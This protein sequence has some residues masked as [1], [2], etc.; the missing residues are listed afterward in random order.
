MKR[1]LLFFFCGLVL[2]LWSARLQ[3]AGQFSGDF[4]AANKLYEQGHYAEAAAA[5]ETLAKTQS[6]AEALFFNLGNAWFKAGQTGRAIAAWRQAEHL[7]PRDPS[8]RF[9]LR[10]ARKKVAGGEGVIGTAWQ[11]ALTTL[12]LNEW[13]VIGAVTLWLW[14]GLLALREIRPALR[15]ALRGYTITAGLATV[16]LAACLG[17]AAQLQ[18]QTIPAVVVVSEAI[19]RSGPLDEAKVLFHFRDGT[20]LTVTDQ[21]ELSAGDQK[22]TWLQV[23]DTSQRLGWVKRDQVIVLGF[24]SQ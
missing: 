3:A 19:A 13:T 17:A 24:R 14:F 22:Q 6:G 11:R 1:A 12:T 16:G 2:V 7:A 15:P 21:K 18:F 4:D 8:I 5:Y 9:N 20:E 10:F 23:R